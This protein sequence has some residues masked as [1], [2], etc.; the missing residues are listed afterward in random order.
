MVTLNAEIE[1]R[2][3]F[4]TPKLRRDDGSERRNREAMMDLN[5]KT[6]NVALN[7]ELK[8]DGGFERQNW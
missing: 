7:I 2:W 5:A 3:W 6:E 1:K 8:I 4:W